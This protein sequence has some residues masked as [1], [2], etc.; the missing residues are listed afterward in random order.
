MNGRVTIVSNK[1]I[2]AF[3][4]EVRSVLEREQD[5]SR[6]SSI[7][8]LLRKGFYRVLA[9]NASADS[10]RRKL[11]APSDVKNVVIFR[12]DAIGDYIVTTPLIRW[13]KKYVPDV[14]IDMIG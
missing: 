3:T 8:D 7:K 2:A 9:R 1:T 14:S 6:H 4:A 13:L 12:Y 5:P 11:L 10:Q